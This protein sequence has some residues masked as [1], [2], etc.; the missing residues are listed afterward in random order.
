[1]VK[2]RRATKASRKVGRRQINLRVDAQLYATLEALARDE[3]RSVAQVAR[4]LVDEGLGH[5][6]NGPATRDDTPGVAIAPLADAG[7][8][9]TW[10]ATEPD[11]YDDNSGEGL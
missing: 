3:Q 1:M 4:R 2:T 7:R 11:L 6:V 9:F 5:R 10:L 8:A